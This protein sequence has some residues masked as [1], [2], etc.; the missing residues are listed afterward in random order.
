MAEKMKKCSICSQTKGCRL[1]HI[2]EN[3]LVCSRCCYEVRG[4]DCGHCKYYVQA[5]K[6]AA[7]KMKTARF[8]DIAMAHSTAVGAEVDSALTYV[9]QGKFAMGEALLTDLLD[10]YP[11]HFLVLYGMGCALAKQGNKQTALSFFDMSLEVYAYLPEAWFN[12][13]VCHSNLLDFGKAVKSY[14]KAIEYSDGT[15]AYMAEARDYLRKAENKISRDFGMSIAQY[16][17]SQEVFD[18]AFSK[19]E[20]QEYEDAIRDFQ[21]VLTWNPQHTQSYGN[22]GLC[23]ALL[24][25]KQKAT[26]AF[27]RA[28][29]IDP[30]Y[31]PARDNKTIMLGLKDG[32]KMPGGKL[33]VVDFYKENV[34]AKSN[35]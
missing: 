15:E 18:S 33:N 23:Y 1:C 19:M 21:K 14:Q 29:E 26:Q 30:K 24:G 28:L 20:N 13:A 8:R 32:E 7:E 6:Y 12:K 25:E 16:L 35:P 9:E 31:V 11:Q 34:E 3:T 4:A 17:K 22:L 5:D 10:K 27:D 2:K